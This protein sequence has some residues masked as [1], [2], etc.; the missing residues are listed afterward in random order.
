MRRPIYTERY[1][2]TIKAALGEPGTQAFCDFA[3]TQHHR[4]VDAAADDAFPDQAA[5]VV[6]TDQLRFDWPERG[7]RYWTEIVLDLDGS[8]VIIWALFAPLDPSNGTKA[9]PV[10]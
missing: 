9:S 8:V 3:A 7:L 6:S 4:V 5:P 10:S 2:A 1:I